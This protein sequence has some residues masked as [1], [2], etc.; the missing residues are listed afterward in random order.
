MIMGGS[1]SMIDVHGN[2][3]NF[4]QIDSLLTLMYDEFLLED[5]QISNRNGQSLERIIYR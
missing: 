5:T 3:T 1:K 4:M 2:P